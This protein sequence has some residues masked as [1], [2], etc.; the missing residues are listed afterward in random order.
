MVVIEG[1][2]RLSGWAM[3]MPEKPEEESHVTDAA[4]PPIMDM[5]RWCVGIHDAFGGLLMAGRKDT[6]GIQGILPASSLGIPQS[7]LPM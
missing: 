1:R 5:L 2:Q 3:I 4:S 6:A 7:W